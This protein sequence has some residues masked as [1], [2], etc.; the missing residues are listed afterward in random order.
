MI[1][2]RLQGGLGNCLFQLAAAYAAV[3]HSSARRCWVTGYGQ[4]LP[5]ASMFS[6]FVQQATCPPATCDQIAERPTYTEPHYHYAPIRIAYNL[7]LEG[8]FQSWRYFIDAQRDVR[9]LLTPSR[10]ATLPPRTV[11]LH[12]RR[13]DYLTKPDC[14]PVLPL[15]YYQHALDRLHGEF[16]YV[17]VVSDD[18]AWCRAHLTA[19]R[20][21]VDVPVLHFAGDVPTDFAVLRH[22][23]HVVMAN[24][25]F[26]WWGAWLNQTP[27]RRVVYPAP[28][29]G[30][31]LPHDTRDLCP[32]EWEVVRWA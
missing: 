16:D 26:S 21:G 20:L 17:A 1:Y 6:P 7:K 2:V 28:W 15:A 29:F 24:S 10:D 22:A 32:P 18:P 12:V 11:A 3:P 5:F 25:T 27:G 14:H 31:A 13:G 19:E 9:D 30:P 8:Y 23:A 4:A